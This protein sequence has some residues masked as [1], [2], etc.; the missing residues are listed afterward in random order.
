MYIT[1][2]RDVLALFKL[3]SK[4][5]CRIDKFSAMV[6]KE[7]GQSNSMPYGN[8][9]ETAKNIYQVQKKEPV[10]RQKL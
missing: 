4:A 7:M 9:Q 1:E 10:Y 8:R 2:I 5:D 6:W 3:W